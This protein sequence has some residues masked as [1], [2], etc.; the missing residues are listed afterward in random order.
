MTDTISPDV[1][2]YIFDYAPLIG[3]VPADIPGRPVVYG[4]L[5]GYQR[6]WDVAY[7]NQHKDFDHA[8]WVDPESD[9]RLFCV[10]AGLGIAP[11]EGILCNGLAIPVTQ[12]ALDEYDRSQDHCYT[13]SG[14]MGS[15]FIWE[16]EGSR[17]N[18]DLPVWVYLPKPEALTHFEEELEYKRV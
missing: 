13:R 16:A 12:E 17:H 2:G 4:T 10:I 3:N 18:L 14:D 6:D 15:D 5:V 9:E 1:I 11:Q 7:S 8:Y